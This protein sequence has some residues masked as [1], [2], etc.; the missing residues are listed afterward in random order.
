MDVKIII[1]S[2]NESSLKGRGPSEK[3]ACYFR[4]KWHPLPLKQRHEDG[5]IAG[6]LL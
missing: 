3:N 4:L 2:K 5:R 1:D 6:D